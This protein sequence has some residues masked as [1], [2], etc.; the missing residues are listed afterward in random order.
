[1][2]CHDWTRSADL[3]PIRSYYPGDVLDPVVC[4]SWVEIRFPGPV[5][6]RRAEQRA[7]FERLFGEGRWR[8]GWRFGEG[9]VDRV[10]ALRA[11]GS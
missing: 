8:S 10:E 11:R 7:G 3:P 4:A 6:R 1:M 5:G 9:I 2:P